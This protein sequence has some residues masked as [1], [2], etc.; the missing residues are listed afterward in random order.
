MAKNTKQHT[1]PGND[2]CVFILTHGRADKVHT[3]NTLKKGGYTGKIYLIIDNED[4][5]AEKYRSL[6]GDSVI[7]FNKSEI[8]KTFDEGD[9]FGDRRTV[10]YARNACFEIAKK[11]GIRYFMQLDDDYTNFSFRVTDTGGYANENESTR[12]KNLDVIFAALLEYYKS[13]PALSIAI[14]QTGDYLGGED[15]PIFTSIWQRRKAMNTFICS[16]D[17]PFKFFG[18]VNE[19]VNTYTAL[20]NRGGMFMTFP[21]LCIKQK[22]T[23]SNSGGMTEMYLDSG[24][25][26]KSFYTVMYNP[27]FV[28][29]GIMNTANA[30]LHHKIRW[31]NAVPCIISEKYR[32]A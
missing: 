1:K 29:V 26:Q 30:R 27:D 12:I 6:Y 22:P 10:I 13:I 2:F 4:K 18:R 17:R 28:R 11:L 24:T 20:Q 32:K 25:Y 16:T 15:A 31:R 23:Q 5:Q 19:D 7:Q 3:F 21:L 8:A 9:N 14:A